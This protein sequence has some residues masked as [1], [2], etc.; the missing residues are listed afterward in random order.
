[1]DE[2]FNNLLLVYDLETGEYISMKNT[3]IET[4]KRT[5]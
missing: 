3:L 5:H 1:M 2:V 4:Y